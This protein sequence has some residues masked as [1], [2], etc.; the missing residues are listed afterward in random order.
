MQYG[1][2][3]HSLFVS[4]Q[5][6]YK[7]HLKIRNSS[8]QQI[9]AV[10][11]IENDGTEMSS[12]SIKLGVDNSTVTRLVDGLEK[13][14]WIKRR[15]SKL[16]NRVVKVFLTKLGKKINNNIESQLHDIGLMVESKIESSLKSH[17]LDSMQILNWSMGKLEIK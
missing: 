3:L 5:C 11:I 12:L 8:F 14:G 6:L 13:Q 10:S 1:E 9:I 16:D 15:K 4:L 2:S 7:N 17:A